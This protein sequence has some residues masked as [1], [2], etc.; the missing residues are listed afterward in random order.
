MASKDYQ[1]KKGNPGGPGRPARKKIQFLL[2]EILDDGGFDWRVDIA[3]AFKSKDTTRLGLYE[4]FAPFLFAT[5]RV[6]EFEVKANTPE[7]SVKN[8][9]EAMRLLEALENGN[10]NANA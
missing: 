7:E 3:Q 6:K 10:I 5:L 1:F 8:A 2:A 9:D 4:K